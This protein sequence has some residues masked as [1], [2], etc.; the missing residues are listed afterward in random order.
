MVYSS[1]VSQWKPCIEKECLLRPHQ[2]TVCHRHRT[3]YREWP[4]IHHCHRSFIGLLATSGQPL[5][6]LDMPHHSN[7]QWGAIA[8][9][10]RL[11]VLSPTC[12]GTNKH[13]VCCLLTATTTHSEGTA[14]ATPFLHTTQTT[15]ETAAVCPYGYTQEFRREGQRLKVQDHCSFTVLTHHMHLY[16]CTF[17]IWILYLCTTCVIFRVLC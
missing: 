6:N 11:R 9:I 1:S 2:V 5:W 10:L 3:P 13:R 4:A 14:T 17:V 12:R 15:L 7:T 8:Q 16:F